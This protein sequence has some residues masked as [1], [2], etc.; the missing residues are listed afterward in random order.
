[1]II[2]KVT[3]NINN[4]I[5]IGQTIKTLENRR[6]SHIQEANR[7]SAFYFHKAIKKH[8]LNN[9]TWE[10][11]KNCNST[12]ELNRQEITYIKYF[13]SLNKGYNMTS[14]GGGTS[15][16]NHS[17]QTKDK[18][19]IAN[20]GNINSLGRTFSHTDNTKDKISLTLGNKRFI[21]IDK[22]TKDVVWFGINQT[23]CAKQL[24]LKQSHISSCLL[25]RR[26]SHGGY[27]FKYGEMD[28]KC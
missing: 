14:G 25:G 3:N 19:A 2:Y 18:I 22:I 5:Y 28:G 8:G 6:K 12:N 23:E 21:A 9:F 16:F 4:K 15:G 26:K 27:I 7:G 11:L 24:D 1:M 20:L 13:D 10:I 17:Q